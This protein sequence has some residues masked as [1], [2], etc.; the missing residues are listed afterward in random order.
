MDRIVSFIKTIPPL[1]LRWVF[2]VFI[3]LYLMVALSSPA[4]AEMKIMADSELSEVTAAGFSKFTLTRGALDEARLDLNLNVSTYTTMDAM[5]MGNWDNG[6][7]QG[8]DQNWQN[9]SLGDL[10]SDLVLKDFVLEAKFTDI[11]NP[12]GRTLQSI[13]M[14][15]NNVTG[16]I[17]TTIGTFTGTIKGTAHQRENLGPMVISLANEP[18]LVTLEVDN[19][20]SFKIGW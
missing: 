12:S 15:F 18:F 3:G 10:G 1:S 2:T 4:L 13:T 11:D 17:S 14:G 7:G 5:Q 8:W 16:T 20:V 6:S 19:G 9:V